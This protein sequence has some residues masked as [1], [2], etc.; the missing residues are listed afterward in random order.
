VESPG[1]GEAFGWSALLDPQDTLFQVRA[2]EQTWALATDGAALESLCRT[3]PER[4][5]EILERTLRLVAGRVKA[6]G[7][8]FAEMCGMRI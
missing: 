3:D 6:S 8:R 2:R 4:G 1:P 5:V 7:I